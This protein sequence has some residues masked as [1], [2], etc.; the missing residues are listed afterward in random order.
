MRWLWYLQLMRW[1]KMCSE[2]FEVRDGMIINCWYPFWQNALGQKKMLI[3]EML[4]I[5]ADVMWWRGQK[6]DV[7][8]TVSFNC[9]SKLVLLLR[10]GYLKPFLAGSKKTK[11]G[12][13]CKVGALC[14]SRCWFYLTVVARPKLIQKKLQNYMVL[15]SF[16]LWS[17]MI[18]MLMLC[19]WWSERCLR[20]YYEIDRMMNW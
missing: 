19:E 18:Q 2:D 11:Q 13:G 12:P 1:M 14:I 20:N 7:G 15:C 10:L 17:L 8:V 4:E 9:K 16:V 5:S 6:N 3:D